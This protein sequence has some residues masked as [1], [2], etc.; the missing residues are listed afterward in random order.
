MGDFS[1]ASDTEKHTDKGKIY[2]LAEK[3]KKIQ[4]HTLVNFNSIIAYVSHAYS[5]LIILVAGSYQSLRAK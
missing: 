4:G 1:I 5:Y 3:W 2:I